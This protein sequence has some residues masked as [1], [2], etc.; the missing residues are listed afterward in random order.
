MKISPSLQVSLSLAL[1]EASRRRH[2]FAGLEHLL[3][4]LTLEKET[5]EVLFHAGTDVRQLS[6]TLKEFLD[7]EVESL[8]GEQLVEPKASLGFQRVIARAAA[9]MDGAGKEEVHGYNVLVSMFDEPECFA[10]YFLEEQGVS[11]LDIVSYI[12]HGVSKVDPLSPG[13]PP[14]E[15]GE[16]GAEAETARDPLASFAQDLVALARAGGIDPLIG[17]RRELRRT[18][19][20]LVRR[21]KSNPVFVGDPGVGKTALAEGLALEIAAGRVPEAL[22]EASVYRLDL[23][24]LLAGTRY[25]GD[26]ENRLKA[27]LKELRNRPKPILFIDEIHTVIGA[28]AAGNS[29]LDASNLLK[30]ALEAGDLRVIG[31]T[32]WKEYRQVFER[33]HALARRFQKVEVEEP[34][35]EETFRILEGLREHYEQH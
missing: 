35:E 15:E 6:R 34:S 23:G 3:L 30:P 29:T 5:G 26:F 13:L 28:G 22:R 27:V 24:A 21:R 4:A 32:T 20:I 8:P 1:T 12:A 10:V 33:D 31:A 25:R 19:H 7:D 17:R 11:R 18:E 9:H 16:E 14:M 2:E